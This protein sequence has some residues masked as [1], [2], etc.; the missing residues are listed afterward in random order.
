MPELTIVILTYNS[1][2]II[3]NSL[4]NLDCNKHKIIVVDNA[5]RD[6]TAELV[7]TNY[8]Q[9]QLIEIAKNGGYGRGN[10]AALNQ[11]QSEFVLVL[12]PDALISED[13]IK[14][15]LQV[16]KSDEKIAIAGPLLLEGNTISAETIAF[17]KA[18]IEKDFT[19]IKHTYYQKIGNNYGSRFISGAC[20]F[21]RTAVFKKLGFFDENIFLFFED[22]EICFRAR[23]NGYKNLLVTNA[24][25]CHIGGASSKKTWRGTYLR[26]WHFKGW[27]KLYWKEIR[28]GKLNSK[29]SA[30]I[31]TGTYFVKSLFALVRFNAEE[32][33]V[34]FGACA[35]S[36][37]F[38][39]GLD[40]FKKDGTPRGII[41]D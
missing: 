40:A 37:A 21:L 28:K 8:P 7:R 39:I 31:L 33:A 23:K 4:D 20:L 35:G 26:N 13:D 12:N 32:M 27:S 5:S 11:L 18:K 1:S 14:K 9:I 34:N 6:N 25:V 2:H 17:E 19:T 16:M 38:L 29:K 30:L 22:D 41:N 24:V 36:V 10:N 3:K 15:V